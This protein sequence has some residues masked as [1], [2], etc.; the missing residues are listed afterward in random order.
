MDSKIKAVF[1]DLDGTLLPMDQDIFTKVYFKNLAIKLAPLGY[2]A[3]KLISAI[4]TGTA[5]MVKNNGSATNETAFWNTFSTIFPDKGRKDEPTFEDFYK[6]EF[7]RAKAAC[8]YTENAKKLIETI[9]EKNLTLVLASNPIFPMIAQKKRM[10]WAGVNPEDFAYITS[11][12]NS[13]YC[14]PNPAYYTEILEK[15][16]L[17]PAECLM[18]GNDAVE[19]TA[20]EKAG[21]NVF[22]LTDCLL[23]KDGR[24][25][26]QYTHGTFKDLFRY[27]SSAI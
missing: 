8:G 9:K 26:S 23:N 10:V 16:N 1:F 25:I 24:D 21:M 20:A 12:E 3:E 14:K 2:E 6:N 4:W 13:S 27:L 18:I 5:S 22:L 19:D 15:M 7:D 11:Y 17:S